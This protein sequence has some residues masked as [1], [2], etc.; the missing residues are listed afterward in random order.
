MKYVIKHTATGLFLAINE[1]TGVDEYCGQDERGI[2]PARF[3]SKAQAAQVGKRFGLSS[4]LGY[5]IEPA[6][7]QSD[8]G[9][10]VNQSDSGKSVSGAN[11]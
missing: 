2:G 1:R 5:E 3:N 10:S 8:S 11:W 6:L 7:N 9:K 4:K